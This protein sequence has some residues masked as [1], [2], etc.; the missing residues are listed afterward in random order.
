M[1]QNQ[2]DLFHVQSAH[3]GIS[4]GAA[5]CHMIGSDRK[6]S[7]AGC[8]DVCAFGLLIK[9]IRHVCVFA[10]GGTQSVH[11]G[12]TPQVLSAEERVS[13]ARGAAPTKVQSFKDLYLDVPW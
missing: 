10:C 12:N 6:A 8:L 11:A 7:K 3:S 1:C 5:R 13:Q 4:V 2:D 9:R